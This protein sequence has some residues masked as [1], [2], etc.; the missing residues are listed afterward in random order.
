MSQLSRGHGRDETAPVTL[1]QITET[2]FC[3]RDPLDCSEPRLG[4]SCREQDNQLVAPEWG[5]STASLGF[6]EL[7]PLSI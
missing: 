2:E 3:K 6:Y 1:I 5:F 7:L 4:K